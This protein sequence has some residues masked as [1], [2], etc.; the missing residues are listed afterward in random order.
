MIPWFF[1]QL[2]DIGSEVVKGVATILHYVHP[3]ASDQN[4]R[5]RMFA[6]TS[7]FYCK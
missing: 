7:N 3:G 5:C 1:L 4:S 6:L 2:D